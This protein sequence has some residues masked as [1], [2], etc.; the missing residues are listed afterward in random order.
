MNLNE[1]KKTAL[2][3]KQKMENG[4]TIYHTAHTQQRGYLRDGKSKMYL[5]NI[6]LDLKGEK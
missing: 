3:K 1:I 2:K 5:E 4:A 6:S